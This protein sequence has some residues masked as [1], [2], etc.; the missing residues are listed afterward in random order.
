[1]A[2]P[3]QLDR[4]RF[5]DD[6]TSMM[7]NSALGLLMLKL[8]SVAHNVLLTAAGDSSDLPINTINSDFAKTVMD[9]M[10]GINNFCHD[11]FDGFIGMFGYHDH[12]MVDMSG[13]LPNYH[14]VDFPIL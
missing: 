2:D 11:V 8:M 5:Q 7:E 1:M 6:F 9:G 14:H 13:K 10:H 4:P 12:G 3:R